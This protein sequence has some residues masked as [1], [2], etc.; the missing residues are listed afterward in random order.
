MRIIEFADGSESSTAPTSGPIQA[1]ALK[2]FANDAA[3]VTDKGSAAAEGDQYWNSTDDQPKY[4]TGGA[5]VQGVTTAGAQ[6]IGG[7]KTFSNDVIVG[8]NLT[9]NGTQ[10]VINSTTMEVDDATITVNKGGN[11]ASAN[12]ARAGVEVEIGGGT[13]AGVGYDSSLAS[14]FKA[15]EIG[16]QSEV[17]TAGHTQTLTGKTI[18]DDNNTIQ[19]VAVTALKTVIGNALKFLSFDAAGAP[20]STKAVPTGAVVGTTDAQVLTAKDYDGGTASNTNRTTLAKETTGNLTALTRKQGNIF[21]DTTKNKPVFDDGTNLNEMGGSGGSGSGRVNHLDSNDSNLETSVGNWITFD[22]GASLDNGTGG[23]PT[24][25]TVER[26]TTAPLASTGDLKISHTAADGTGEGASVPFTS[27]NADKS[28]VQEISFDY[29]TTSGYADDVM[30]VWIYDITNS[31]LISATPNKLKASLVPS[32]FKAFFQN[33]ASSTSYRLIFY[34]ASAAATAFDIQI[35]NLLVGPPIYNYGFVGS[36]PK[37]YSLVIGGTTTAPTLG[38]TPLNRATCARIGKY[39]LIQYQLTQTSLGS[40]GSGTYLFPLPSGLQIDPAYFTASSN[41]IDNS[42]GSAGIYTIDA[43]KSGAGVVKGYN[44]TNLFLA[45]QTDTNNL[46][47]V[48]SGFYALGTTDAQISFTAM[49]PILGWS[50]NVQLSDEADLRI[51]A[52]RYSRATTQSIPN[53]TIEIVEFATKTYDTHGSVSVGPWKYTA[54]TS[55]YRKV[56]AH[57]QFTND[58]NNYSSNVYLYKNGSLY[59]TISRITVKQVDTD[60]GD[61]VHFGGDTVYMNA[62]DYIDIRCDQGSGGALDIGNDGS[63]SN[64]VSIEKV[65]GPSA[66]APTEKILAKYTATS[67]T[68]NIPNSSAPTIFDCP[69][70]V[71]DT[72]NAVSTGSGWQFTC[73][74]PGDYRITSVIT[75]DTEAWVT[76]NYLIMSAYKESVNVGC[77]QWWSA[78]AT[79][80]LQF[81]IGGSVVVPNCLA[82]QILQVILE[83]SRAAGDITGVEASGTKN[84]ITIE[85]ISGV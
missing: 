34:C 56:N 70:K 61:L 38:T 35:D 60:S 59:S 62:T 51:D 72:H 44:A 27:R 9:V 26:N 32:K 16:S 45:V 48:G 7:N 4:Y 30:E 41:A 8:G 69:T 15:G 49:V 43:T 29:I 73:P 14:K 77:M 10:T 63:T 23:S 28:S 25:V 85:R 53:A 55:G 64:Y 79:A 46:S 82:G 65:Q 24:V 21:Y 83:S 37:E 68:N 58:T 76:N 67:L 3:Y 13:D 66:I 18:D 19:N 5:W 54:K 47:D 22:D 36:D 1:T 78:A 80:S 40:S 42:L 12:A 11:A 81:S 84:Q 57:V 52:A 39:A 20:I 75:L 2:V 50:S 6:T 74:A 31:R 33:D 17:I 71:I